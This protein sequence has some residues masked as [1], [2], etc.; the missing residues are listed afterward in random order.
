MQ[1]LSFILVLCSAAVDLTKL[2]QIM[3]EKAHLWNKSFSVGVYSEATGA[4]GVASGLN[5]RRYPGT[6]MTIDDRF[7]VGSVTKPWTVAAIMRAHEAGLLDIDAP[8][9][10]YVDPV[11]KRLN[12]T[13]MIELWHNDLT[14]H[15][16]TARLLMA[17]RSGLQAY[18]DTWYH[19]ITLD[20]PAH[21]VTPIDLVNRLNKTFLCKPGE[22]YKYA[23]TGY[24]LLGLA[25][26]EVHNHTNWEEY[27]QLTVLPEDIRG[28]Y[29]R[30]A[31]PGRGPC[32][33]DPMIVHQYANIP[34]KWVSHGSATGTGGNITFLDIVNNSCLNGWTCGNIAAGPIDIARFHYHLHKL[35]IVSNSSLD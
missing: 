33:K 7:P 26:T 29:N 23:S 12:G 17:M 9:G 8:I 35:R 1:R 21:D 32:S 16:V 5:D 24:E 27:D 4:F 3:D 13:T 6:P 20:Q 11:L 2:Q 10:N 14:I 28:Q 22:C 25:L 34:Y 31:F 18:N 15:N 30:T 19:Q